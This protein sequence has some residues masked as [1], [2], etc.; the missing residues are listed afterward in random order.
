MAT[1]AKSGT[2]SLATM[3]P[4]GN[5]F[6]G[7]NFKAG[8]AIAGGDPCY[9]KNDGKVYRSVGTTADAARAVDGW[10]PLAAASG[11]AVTLMTD[12]D[13]HYGASLTPGTRLY[14]SLTA[15]TIQDS[16]SAGGTAAIG[17]V[18]DTTRI[19]VWQTRY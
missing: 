10:A 1:V 3:L 12:V 11:E 18:I 13:F 4:G 15:G 14:L 7:S 5:C 19:R 9:I 8:E 6:V 16:A 2:P 17:M